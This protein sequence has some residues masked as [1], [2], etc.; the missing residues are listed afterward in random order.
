MTFHHETRPN[1]LRVNL[2]RNELARSVAAGFFVRTGSRDE[3]PDIAGV[4]HFLEHMVFKGTDRRDVL[5]V[6]RDFD[7]IGARHNA[8][9]SEEDTIYHVSCLPEYLPHALDVLADIMRETRHHRRNQ[10]V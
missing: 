1:G 3:S 9:T 5:A 4:S 7:R 6:N 10:D 2:E 8:Q